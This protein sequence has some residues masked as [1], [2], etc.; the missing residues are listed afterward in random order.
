MIQ[1]ATI[2]VIRNYQ[3]AYIKLR[4]K[5]IQLDQYIELQCRCD[6]KRATTY[7]KQ[8]KN[9]KTEI[10]VLKICVRKYKRLLADIKKEIEGSHYR[11]YYYHNVI[12]LSLQETAKRTG[13]SKSGV[14][15]ILKEINRKIKE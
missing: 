2:L 3:D 9:A 7:E 1:E 4:L 14:C 5:R 11:V 10:E 13:Y 15:K 6:T 8:I 12:E